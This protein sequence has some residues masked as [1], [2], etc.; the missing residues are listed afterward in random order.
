MGKRSQHVSMTQECAFVSKLVLL[1][2]VSIIFPAFFFFFFTLLMVTGD[3]LFISL[4]LV[5]NSDED[6][7]LY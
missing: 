7:R 6:G 4:I 3:L 2:Y 5:S 1:G